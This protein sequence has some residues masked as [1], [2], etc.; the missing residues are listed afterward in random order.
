MAR[1]ADPAGSAGDPKAKRSEVR[2][3]SRMA[4]FLASEIKQTDWDT[5]HGLEDSAYSD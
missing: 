3:V 1:P 5:F 2:L 4:S